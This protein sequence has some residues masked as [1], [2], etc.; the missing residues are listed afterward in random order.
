MDLITAPEDGRV[1]GYQ[2]IT[3]ARGRRAARSKA[4]KE[5]VRDRDIDEDKPA[6][7]GGEGVQSI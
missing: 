3:S 1:N 5:L 7:S 4:R 2:S 6:D